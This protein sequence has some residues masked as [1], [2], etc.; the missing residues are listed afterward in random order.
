MGGG[1]TG[2]FPRTG[3]QAHLERSAPALRLVCSALSQRARSAVSKKFLR[4]YG[5]QGGGHSEFDLRRRDSARH[6]RNRIL[7]PL[8]T[9]RLGGFGESLARWENYVEIDPNVRD[10]FGIPV[11]RMHMTYGENERAMV[12]DMA[13]S[14][15]EM[16][17]AAGAK[18]IC[19]LMRPSIPGWA[20]HEVGIARM[21]NDPKKT[22][23][24]PF[25]ADP[26]C[27]EPVRD[28]WRR[29]SFH[30]LPEPHFDHHG[31]D[32]SFLRLPD[33]REEERQ[34]SRI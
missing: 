12:Q 19:P 24:N 29:L 31:A 10:T 4:G 9:V 27:Q 17:E 16:L 6:T 8:T 11:L 26:R 13:D 20:I 30:R 3:H 5:F 1:A 32:G 22:V 21:G 25:P 18:N 23:L 28:G 14:A 33:A 2:E 15:A 34:Q 7:N